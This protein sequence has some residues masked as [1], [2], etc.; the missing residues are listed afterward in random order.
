MVPSPKYLPDPREAVLAEIDEFMGETGMAV[1]T[2]SQKAGLR[3]A[4]IAELR[5]GTRA[6]LD[7]IAKIYAFMNE[8]RQRRMEQQYRPE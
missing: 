2:L 3:N 8:E 1:T 6:R 5:M 4:A 7:T